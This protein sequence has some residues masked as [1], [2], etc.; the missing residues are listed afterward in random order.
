MTV[1]I[2][3]IETSLLRHAVLAQAENLLERLREGVIRHPRLLTCES[4]QTALG[5]SLGDQPF[6]SVRRFASSVNLGSR[7]L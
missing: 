1:A 4:V 7:W 6:R 3:S 5:F 2:S